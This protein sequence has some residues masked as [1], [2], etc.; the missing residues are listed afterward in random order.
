MNKIV[1]ILR[2]TERGVPLYEGAGKLVVRMSEALTFSNSV[3]AKYH[4]E[5]VHGH[6]NFIV[7]QF[8]PTF[9]L[10]ARP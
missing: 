5:K 6:S 3:E 10:N 8:V 2:Y 4:C 1:I 7:E 9:N